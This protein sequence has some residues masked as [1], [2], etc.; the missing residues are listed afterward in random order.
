MPSLSLGR[1]WR[2]Q[3]P[4]CNIGY[5][6]LRLHYQIQELCSVYTQQTLIYAPKLSQPL[7]EM[8]QR[9]LL[10]RTELKRTRSYLFQQCSP[11]FRIC[12][13]LHIA[14]S[15]ESS[16]LGFLTAVKFSCFNWLTETFSSSFLFL[17]SGF[18]L[19]T[20]AL[21]VAESSSS[22]SPANF[23]LLFCSLLFFPLIWSF[24]I[25]RVWPLAYN[26]KNWNNQ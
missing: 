14:K 17:G 12:L 5:F 25:F 6:P 26:R 21:V 7:W 1:A 16:L 9:T 3:R 22:V 11:K 2:F 24:F 13:Y 19:F 4:Y 10:P 8:C 20:E 23:L 18:P 15:L